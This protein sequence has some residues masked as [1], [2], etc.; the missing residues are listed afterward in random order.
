[1]KTENIARVLLGL[2]IIGGIAWCSAPDKV[3]KGSDVTKVSETERTKN[4]KQ[5]VTI[6][7]GEE[8]TN[9][10]SVEIY[11][12]SVRP[13]YKVVSERKLHSEISLTCHAD[14]EMYVETS[15]NDTYVEFEFLSVN[16]ETR[17]AE[18]LISAKLIDYNRVV[19][20]QTDKFA[21]LD[22][23]RLVITG[24]HFDNLTKQM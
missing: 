17:T 8:D 15:N 22:D 20:N 11:R 1:M 14:G 12:E 19:K 10:C 9:W 7:F 5:A 24:Q 4:D 16:K 2:I 13:A 3:I 23:I 6:A 18:A 21:E